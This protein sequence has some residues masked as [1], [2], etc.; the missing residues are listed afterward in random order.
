MKNSTKKKDSKNVKQPFGMDNVHCFRPDK[1]FSQVIYKK[2]FAPKTLEVHF[3]YDPEIP[4]AGRECKNVSFLIKIYGH[5][6]KSKGKRVSN[7][8]RIPFYDTKHIWYFAEMLRHGNLVENYIKFYCDEYCPYGV[9]PTEKLDFV[10]KETD[11][12]TCMFEEDD[13]PIRLTTY[14]PFH[15]EDMEEEKEYTL[16][17]AQLHYLPMY[18]GEKTKKPWL[19]SVDRWVGTYYGMSEGNPVLMGNVEQRTEIRMTPKEFLEF[20]AVIQNTIG[21]WQNNAFIYGEQIP[22]ILEYIFQKVPAP[23]NAKKKIQWLLT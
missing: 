2:Q 10:K 13:T 22:D 17:A 5:D 12:I 16:Y 8:I 11:R 20:T 15:E 21:R 23:K 9:S 1:G 19:F 7:E 14:F 6:A 3:K 4:T 18:K